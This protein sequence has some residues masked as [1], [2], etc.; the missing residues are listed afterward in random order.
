MLLT[1]VGIIALLLVN[2]WLV[3]L[4][5]S[6][7]NWNRWIVAFIGPLFLIIPLILPY[8]FPNFIWVLFLFIFIFTNIY[9]FE[10]SREMVE[11]NDIR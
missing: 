1:V 6:K 8:E 5:K 10:S 2:I 7:V 9:F 11:N 4:L 3:K